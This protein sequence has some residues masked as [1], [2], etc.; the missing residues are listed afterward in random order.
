MI[1][2]ILGISFSLYQV[3][4]ANTTQIEFRDPKKFLSDQG[5]RF[6]T[7]LRSGIKI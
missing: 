5:S 4:A 2:T 6:A 3:Y 7:I 1:D